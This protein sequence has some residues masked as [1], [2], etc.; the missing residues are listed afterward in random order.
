M[1]LTGAT[2]TV[3]APHEPGATFQLRELAW[4]ELDEAADLRTLTRKRGMVE[5]REMFAAISP[6]QIR[7]AMD[8]RAATPEAET[9][10]ADDYDKATLLRYGLVGWSYAEP[11]TP[12]GYLRLDRAT[13][14]WLC[15]EIAPALVRETDDPKPATA[16]STARSKAEAPSPASGV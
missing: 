14:D 11:W 15:G 7:A 3:E 2:R 10:A 5:L 4:H 12:E 1:A 16:R 9:D 8:S 6:E 13:A